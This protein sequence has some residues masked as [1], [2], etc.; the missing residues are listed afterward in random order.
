MKVQ[1]ISDDNGSGTITSLMVYKCYNPQQN[2]FEHKP[3]C[4]IEEDEFFEL[5]KNP[6]LAIKQ[7]QEGKYIF[8]VPLKKLLEASI[9]NYPTY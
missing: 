5:C 8:D 3:C 6:E 9:K 1:I 4:K 2:L 7:A